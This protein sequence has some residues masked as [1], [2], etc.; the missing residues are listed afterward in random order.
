MTVGVIPGFLVIEA[1][2]ASVTLLR[3]DTHYKVTCKEIPGRSTSYLAL[4][5]QIRT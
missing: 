2:W 3:A 4:P 1:D 5:P